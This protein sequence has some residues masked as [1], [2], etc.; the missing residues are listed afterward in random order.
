MTAASVSKW[1]RWFV[2]ASVSF[3]VVWQLAA[4][5]GVPRRTEVVLGVYGFVLHMVFGKAYSLLPA[6]FDRSLSP[7]WGP[8]VHL[9]ATVA[10]R[11]VRPSVSGHPVDRERVVVH[12]DLAR[13]D[14]R[15]DHGDNPRQRDDG[16]DEH[17]DADQDGEQ[18]QTEEDGPVA[19]PTWSS[20]R[21]ENRVV[22]PGSPRVPGET[23]AAAA[24]DP[25]GVY[26]PPPP[27]AG[28]E[29]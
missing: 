18:R 26:P 14:R 2:I 21:Y 25:S 29:R 23:G 3:L 10:G 13:A 20:S 16:S 6:Y 5:A 1:A 7:T 4:L 15:Q 27:I 8:G 19:I 11:W 28:H 24:E 9:P 12:L 22:R 17:P